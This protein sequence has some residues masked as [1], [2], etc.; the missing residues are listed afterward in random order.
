MIENC[1]IWRKKA[2]KKFG[3]KRWFSA[4]AV[5]SPPLLHSFILFSLKA[6][7]VPNFRA[8]T[9]LWAE[10]MRVLLMVSKVAHL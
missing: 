5:D 2:N 9:L 8:V 1:L 6:S 3:G 7:A 10:I 4:G